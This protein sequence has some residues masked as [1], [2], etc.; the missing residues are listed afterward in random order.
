MRRR[1]R[2]RNIAKDTAGQ[3]KQV[4]RR[5]LVWSLVNIISPRRDT[6]YGCHRVG[7]D[8]ILWITLT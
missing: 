2:G 7:V 4:S 5:R 3:D 6:H 8:I 1:L